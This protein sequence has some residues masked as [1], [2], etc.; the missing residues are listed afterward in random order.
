M[1]IQIIETVNGEALC[2][3]TFDHI[4]DAAKYVLQLISGGGT[5][6]IVIEKA[7]TTGMTVADS[8]EESS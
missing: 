4:D 3:K 5:E 1:K 2:G 7:T 8:T 6:K